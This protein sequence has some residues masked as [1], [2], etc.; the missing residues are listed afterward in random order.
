MET[1]GIIADTHGVLKHEILT[2]LFK[3]GEKVITLGDITEKEMGIIKNRQDVIASVRGN[4]DYGSVLPTTTTFELFSK[5]FFCSHIPVNIYVPSRKEDPE[6]GIDVVLF[7]HIHKRV[8]QKMG[9][10]H[11]FSPG[12]LSKN[13]DNTMPSV[14]ILEIDDKKD[15]KF[16]FCEVS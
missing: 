11:F 8:N 5:R 1:I 6:K 13:R 9:G 12:S 2:A 4:C 15:L 7:A 16:E 3:E 14:G 10:V